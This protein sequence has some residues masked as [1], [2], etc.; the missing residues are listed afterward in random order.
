MEI[1]A[2]MANQLQSLQ[3]LVQMSVMNK[4]LAMS[5]QAASDMLK[6]MPEQPAQ[7]PYKGHLIDLKA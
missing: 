4:S 2:M 1:N 6:G 7:H 5:T 3:S